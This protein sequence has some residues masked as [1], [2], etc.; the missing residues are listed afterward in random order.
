MMQK[1][2]KEI[3]EKQGR[4]IL[5]D[6][7]AFLTKDV[8]DKK[9]LFFNDVL[10]YN[11]GTLADYIA[12]KEGI[13][14]TAAQ[15]KVANYIITI[16]NGLVSD[17]KFEIDDLGMLYKDQ[18]GYINFKAIE[19][20]IQ[21]E[22]KKINESAVENNVISSENDDILEIVTDSNEISNIKNNVDEIISAE[23]PNNDEI[24]EIEEENIKTE[25]IIEEK[26]KAE[27]IEQN[28]VIE[29]PKIEES[30]EIIQNTGKLIEFNSSVI[31]P[32]EKIESQEIVQNDEKLE[33]KKE[34]KSH[35]SKKTVKDK[36]SI[37]KELHKTANHKPKKS[38]KPFIIIASIVIPIIILGVIGFVFKEKAMEF[39]HSFM[40][41]T[42][43]KKEIVEVKKKITEK[44]GEKTTAID[45]TITDANGKTEEI[46]T[47]TV[48]KTE[49]IA[50]TKTNEETPI[51]ENK[52]TTEK[53]VT[54]NSASL[55]F[56]A[57]AGSFTNIRDAEKFMNKIKEQGYNSKILDSDNGKIRVTYNSFATR[58][59]AVNE[60]TKLTASGLQSWVLNQ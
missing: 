14:K 39:V 58:Q 23:I 47:E 19:S 30:K 6:L 24:L 25:P 22:P 54:N 4:L 48:E 55:K 57:I 52:V 28:I 9:I 1:Y 29:E 42:G 59:E 21:E 7:G 32:N 43:H 12:E 60:V 38:L 44:D 16:N 53:T 15:S 13:D 51:V 11:D 34:V 45:S 2:I 50:E 8:D 37:E 35:E 27:F 20:D 56:H 33:V 17:S 10:K 5:P 3:I 31:E 49:E 41:K 18:K 26:P 46:K 40:G 36:K